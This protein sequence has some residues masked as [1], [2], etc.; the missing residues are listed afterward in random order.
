MKKKISW[1]KILKGTV[2]S[3]SE[4]NVFKMSA[5]LAY[6]TI[7]SMGPLLIIVISLVGIFYGRSAA[8]GEVYHQL[9]DLVGDKPAEQIQAIIQNLRNEDQNWLHAT[10]GAVVLI[11]GATTV[12]TQM[13]DSIN[14]IWRVKAKPKKGWVK[15]LKNRLLSFSLVISLGFLLLVSLIVSAVLDVFSEYL[16]AFLADYTVYLFY[17]INFAIILAVISCLF[18]VIFKVLPDATISWKDAFIGAAFTSLLFLLGKYGI[19]I[20]LGQSDLS[21]T[22]GA[23]ASIIIILTW[24]YYSALILYFGAEFTRMYAITAGSGITPNDTAVYVI[25]RESKEIEPKN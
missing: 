15:F 25:K 11:I 23:A 5:S 18:A 1:G 19:S 2:Q 10:I 22:Y 12:F 7:F 6:Y 16:K 13:Q 24:V 14:I 17:V 21:S 8:E 4:D 9:R 20:Y 3:F